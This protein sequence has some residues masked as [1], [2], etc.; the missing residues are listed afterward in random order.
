MLLKGRWLTKGF[1]F[2]GC[3][4]GRRQLQLNSCFKSTW[5][6]S[7]TSKSTDSVPLSIEYDWT[8]LKFPPFFS[9]TKIVFTY[10]DHCLEFCFLLTL[11]TPGGEPGTIPLW[12][13]KRLK[14]ATEN[15]VLQHQGKLQ[16]LSLNL[17]HSQG[18]VALTANIKFRPQNHQIDWSILMEFFTTLGSGGT[19][20]NWVWKA[21]TALWTDKVHDID[22][23][24]LLKLLDLLLW[25]T[26]LLHDLNEFAGLFFLTDSE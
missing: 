1:F 16:T 24:A 18:H 26:C 13:K 15:P 8:S 9:E 11:E 22:I 7:S 12:V 17:V 19:G 3:G 14:K 6:R 25:K 10:W 5:T 2:R 21:A 4:E 23:R 20:L